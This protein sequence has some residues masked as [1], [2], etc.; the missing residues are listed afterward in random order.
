MDAVREGTSSV[1]ERGHHVILGWSDVALPLIQEFALD[2]E[3]RGGCKIVVMADMSCPDMVELV[4][5]MKDLRGTDVICRRCDDDDGRYVRLLSLTRSLRRGNPSMTF[6]LERIRVPAAKTVVI[7]ASPGDPQGADVGTLRVLLA[8]RNLKR[9]PRAQ[10]VAQLNKDD[11]EAV[12]KMVGG[13]RTEVVIP[14]GTVRRR[15]RRRRPGPAHP[16]SPP[17][18]TDILGRMMIQALREPGLSDVWSQLLSFDRDEF[19]MSKWPVLT[20]KSF[21]EARRFFETAVVVGIVNQVTK[22]VEVNP[23]D[24]YTIA[25]DDEIVVIAEDD[26]MYVLPLRCMPPTDSL[27]LSSSS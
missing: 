17:P 15:R 4:G 25:E 2:A 9:K 13:E 18:P 12:V 23:P 24:T 22:T 21:G 27:P 20:G 5:E 10:V 14:H 16:S 3:D 8:L 7:I 6:D 1:V 19:Y 26:S 11:N